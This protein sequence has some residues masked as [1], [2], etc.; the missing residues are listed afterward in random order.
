MIFFLAY[1][2]PIP[3]NPALYEQAKKKIMR[4][5]KK[6]SAFASGAVV[7][8]YKQQGGK[9]KEDGKPKNLERWFEEEWINVNPILGVTN[10]NA[11]RLFDRQKN[12]Q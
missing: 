2:M 8:E 1:Y 3:T 5:Y 6:P 9:Y 10:E 4:S 12:K 11:Y 7:K